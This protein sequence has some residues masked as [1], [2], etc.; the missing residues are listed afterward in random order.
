MFSFGHS[1]SLLV[2]HVLSFFLFSLFFSPFSFFLKPFYRSYRYESKKFWIIC[3]NKLLFFLFQDC[4]FM[5]A[6][7]NKNQNQ[8]DPMIENI[9][10]CPFIPLPVSSPVQLDIWWKWCGVKSKRNCL[11]QNI[12]YSNNKCKALLRPIQSRGS[13]KNITIFF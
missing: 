12:S 6:S 8:Q 2:I 1:R 9:K 4:Q 10:L 13:R 3:W 7:F 5:Q 11:Y